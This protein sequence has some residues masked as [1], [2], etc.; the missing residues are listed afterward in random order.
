MC[1]IAAYV[2]TRPAAPVLIE[3]LRRQEGLNG[4]CYVGIATL[5]EGRIHYRKIV[6]TLDRLLAETDAACLP[7]TVGLIHTRTPGGG[8]E[9]WGHPFL[10][11]KNGVPVTAYVLNGSRSFFS[12]VPRNVPRAESLI[13]D[14]YT[15]RTRTVGGIAGEHTPLLE[16]GTC[17]HTSEIMSNLILRNLDRGMEPA[18]AM[19][20]AMDE[21]PLECVGLLLSVAHPDR[22]SYSRFNMPM[23]LGFAEHGC[24]MASAALCFPEDAG[25]PLPVPAGSVGY[26]Y[27]DHYESYPYKKLPASLAPITARVRKE[28]YDAVVA[29]LKDGNQTVPLLAKLVAPIFDEADCVQK[30]M[31]VYDILYILHREGRLKY[32]TVPVPWGSFGF[33]YPQFR[34]RLEK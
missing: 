5:H 18:F 32:D 12:S 16:D 26:V 34:F 4:G 3:M 25:Y 33:S 7:G 13:K 24:Y 11:E 31:L 23:N 21:F 17:V 2:G 29:A 10:G 20:A 8:N 28:G 30:A 9:E 1:N 6:G 15:F 27:R 14:G 19:E 22:I